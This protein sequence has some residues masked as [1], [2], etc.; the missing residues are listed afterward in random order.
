MS[1]TLIDYF[2]QTTDPMSQ[3]FIADLLRASDLFKVVKFE[4]VDGLKV[5]GARWQTLPSTGFRKIGE[6][7]SE[8]TGSAE[9]F[10]E[11]LAILGGDVKVDK[12]IQLARNVTEDPLITQMKMKAK[13]IAF[14]FNDN[15]VNGDH[16]SD[17]DCFEGLK[18]RVSN[19]PA[20]MT[21]DCYNTCDAGDG[22]AILKNSTNENYFVDALHDAIKRVDGATHIFCNETVYLGLSRVLRRLGLLDTNTDAYGKVWNTFA[23]V[24]LVDIGLKSDKST[25]IITLTENPGDGHTDCT[26]LYVARMDTDDGLHGIQLNGTSPKPYDP[27]NGGEMEGGPQYLRR[28][29]WAVGLFNLSQY[30]I[31]RLK[32]FRVATA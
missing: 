2:K 14:T 18:V 23:G 1:V 17:P 15:F 12:V 7:Y 24:P 16:S 8:S 29:D 22:L 10:G 21:I 30:C 31:C 25:E 11:T 28:I 27:L 26:S 19:M 6:G 20:R 9:D 5:T 13:S 32:G 3:G 4:S